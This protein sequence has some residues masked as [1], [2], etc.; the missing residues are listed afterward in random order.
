MS[1]FTT[2]IEI[3]RGETKQIVQAMVDS[4][5]SG[6]Y[7]KKVQYFYHRSQQFSRAACEAYVYY[8]TYAGPISTITNID[9]L[10][11][12]IYGKVESELYIPLR[13]VGVCYNTSG[14]PTVDDVKLLTNNVYGNYTIQ[15]IHYI[16]DTS[17]EPVLDSYGNYIFDTYKFG[18]QNNVNY[19][20]RPY[21]I[22]SMGVI[23]GEQYVVTPVGVGYDIIE[24][25]LLVY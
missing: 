17:S 4:F 21:T 6:K 20:F 7:V 8:T 3:L 9:F 10:T 1:D 12:T 18:K 11:S 16:Q 24:E 23:Y 5:I 19:Y 25:T 2:K 15:E 14:N 13:Q 22:S